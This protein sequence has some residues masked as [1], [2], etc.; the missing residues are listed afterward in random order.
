[1]HR[2]MTLDVPV[3]NIIL[4]L[5]VDLLELFHPYCSLTTEL[6]SLP[7]EPCRPAGIGRVA[8]I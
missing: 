2:M 8:I 6:L 3:Q 1:M 4:N 7:E 5:M